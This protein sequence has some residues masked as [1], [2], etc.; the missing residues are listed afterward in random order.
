MGRYKN[1]GIGKGIGTSPQTTLENQEYENKVYELEEKNTTL[2]N[3]FNNT[4]TIN[5]FN[6]PFEF[7]EN[8]YEKYL[9]DLNHEDGGSKAK[10][11]KDVL[12]YKLGDGKILHGAILEAVKNK[13]PNEV[14]TTSYGIKY[15][16]K[17]LIKGNNGSYS[18]A[19]VEIVIQK[20]NG[21]TIWRI[22][23]IY[24]GE[25]VK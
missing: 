7:S 20:D 1:S 9:F 11:L 18:K 2:N 4:E 3:E 15:L 8:K 25:K 23:T 16:F 5:E 10:F 21:K 22:I 14:K 17:T 19:N 6:F 12:G 13:R 24:P